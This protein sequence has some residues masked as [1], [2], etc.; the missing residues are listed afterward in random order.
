MAVATN[1]PNAPNGVDSIVI[2]SDVDIYVF[3]KQDLTLATTLL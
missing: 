3:N 2:S 1:D